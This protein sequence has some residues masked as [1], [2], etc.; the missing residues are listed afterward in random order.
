M[1][2]AKDADMET[3][4]NRREGFTCYQQSRMKLLSAS[5]RTGVSESL[6]LTTSHR[7][8]QEARDLGHGRSQESR[9]STIDRLES[10]G[11]A[12]AQEFFL[13]F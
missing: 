1:L 6:V 5:S 8:Q 7:A 11:G 4:P 2:G 10:L 9:V 13:F 12:A 3:K